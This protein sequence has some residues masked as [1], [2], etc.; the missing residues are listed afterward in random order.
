[1]RPDDQPLGAAWEGPMVGF[2][3]F[4]LVIDGMTAETLID[5]MDGDRRRLNLA[6][7]RIKLTND[8]SA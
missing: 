6:G 4:R 8:E 5:W 1:M 7:R 3:S 2:Q